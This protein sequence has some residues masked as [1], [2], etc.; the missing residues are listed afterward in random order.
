MA[1]SGGRSVGPD[2]ATTT[3]TT[4]NDGSRSIS[5]ADGTT[6]ALGAKASNTWGMAAP[7][8]TPEVAT[9]P[10][11]VVSKT[12]VMQALASSG[13]L[14]YALTGTITSTV[15]GQAWTQA[16]DPT[17]RTVTL[18][19]PAGRKSVD[20]YDPDGH[21]VSSSAPGSP[22]V[23][24]SYDGS[25]RE[26]S[27][28]VGS[29]AAAQTTKYAYDASKGQLSITRPDG[30]VV[31]V[32]VDADGRAATTT[33]PDGS[34]VVTGYDADGRLTEVQPPGGLEFVLGSSPA[35]RPTAF[36]PPVAGTDASAELTTYDGDG[37]PVSVAGL[38]TRAIQVAYDSAGRVVGWTF[39]RG[40]RLGDLRPDLAPPGAGRRSRWR[41]H[42]VRLRRSRPR[43]AGLVRSAQRVGDGHPRRERAS[44]HRGGRR[45]RPAS[46]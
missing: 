40:Q 35:G 42:D 14:P 8:L 23:T 16:F 21:L 2:G 11:G 33:A 10:D 12:D 13:G 28:T 6:L 37:A 5:F 39:D 38:G 1:A 46:R 18:L 43:Q 34:T 17:A 4:N 45:A 22:T 31:L 3:E 9:R 25:G 32:A 44:R 41:D 29:G 20:A 15:N 36:V 24:R 26:S 7:V 19:D 27:Q 30:S